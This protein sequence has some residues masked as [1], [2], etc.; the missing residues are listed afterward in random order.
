[1]RRFRLPPKP[2]QRE[3]RNTIRAATALYT[4]APME[5]LEAPIRQSSPR[6]KQA[7][8]L[9]NKAVQQVARVQY[10]AE[11]R[12]NRIGMVDLPNG[13][14]LPFG[15]GA[16]T[17]D[18]VGPV[19]MVITPSMVGRTVSIYCEVEQKTETGV[20]EQHQQDRIDHL[21]DMGAISGVCRSAEDFVAVVER[22]RNR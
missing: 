18:L 1:M 17:L 4:G 16:G 3:V 19:P 15:L 7:E 8:S 5:E 22:W 13:G 20:V 11:L 2:S 14:K 9:V 12:R 6:G 10:R 21:R